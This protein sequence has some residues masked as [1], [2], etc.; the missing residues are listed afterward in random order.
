MGKGGYWVPA[1]I[2][3]KK[4]T[5]SFEAHTPTKLKGTPWLYCKHCGLVYLRNYITQWCIKMGCN[6]E[7]HPEYKMRLKM[8]CKKGGP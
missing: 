7:Y 2:E 4:I 8:S 6:N 5:Y 3:D 1:E